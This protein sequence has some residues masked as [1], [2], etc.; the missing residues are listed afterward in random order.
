LGKEFVDR[1]D[2]D[3]REH[4]LTLVGGIEEIGHR[5]GLSAVC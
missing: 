3:R 5:I 2:A 1:L 4:L